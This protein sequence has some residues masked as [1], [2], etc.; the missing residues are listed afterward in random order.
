MQ[1]KCK[2]NA[3][4]TRTERRRNANG[5]QTKWFVNDSSCKRIDEAVKRK[6]E[7]KW[8]GA[9]GHVVSRNETQHLIT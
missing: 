4:G 7:T 1:M 8:N 3:H 2:R 9:F 6:R 5:T